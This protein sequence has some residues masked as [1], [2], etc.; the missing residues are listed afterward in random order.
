MSVIPILQYPNPRL[1][2]KAKIVTEKEI[3][4]SLFQKMIDDMLETLYAT[5]NCAGLAATQLDIADPYQVTVIDV[6]DSKAKS[7]C[8]INPEIIYQEGSVTEWEACMSV[9]PETIHAQRARA[10]KIKARALD[11]EG[12]LQEIEAEGLLAKCIQHEIDHLNGHLYIDQLSPLKRQMVLKRLKK[13]LD[14]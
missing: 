2:K 3:K 4:D 6:S 14:E 10:K 9:F 13:L 5:P 7:Y 11:R 1:W 8:L 12:N